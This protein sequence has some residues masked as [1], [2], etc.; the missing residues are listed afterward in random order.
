MFEE[1]EEEDINDMD[2][3]VADRSSKFIHTVHS[4]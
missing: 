4:T 1:E 3:S 2:I